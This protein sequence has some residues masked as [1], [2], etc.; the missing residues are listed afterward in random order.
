MNPKKKELIKALVTVHNAAD[1]STDIVEGKGNGLIVLL[2]GFVSQ[3]T[4]LVHHV[5]IC[6]QKPWNWKDT[7]SR[8]VH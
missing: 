1:K 4:P 6:Q 3:S 8:Y 2:H 5:D 7:D